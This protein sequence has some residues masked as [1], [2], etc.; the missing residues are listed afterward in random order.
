MTDERADILGW[1]DF[2]ASQTRDALSADDARTARVFRQDR[3]AFDTYALDG[4]EVRARLG[5][6][7]SYRASDRRELPAVGDWVVVKG[8]PE[9][10]ATI[11]DVYDRKSSLMRQAAS[12]ATD[13]QIIAANVDTVFI[14]TSPNQDFNA[15]RLERYL[16]AVQDG[17]AEP[18]VV[19]NK[20]D[21]VDDPSDWVD[22]A[23]EAAGDAHVVT[24][25]AI[26]GHVAALE[27]WLG[28]GETVALVGSSGVGKSTLINQLLG[29]DVQKTGGIREDDG[30]GRHTTVTRELLV[31]P[32]E[33]GLLI[34]TPGLRELQLWAGETQ[35]EEAFDDIEA[36]A[37]ECKFR[38][39]EHQ[40][41]PGCAVRDAV[42][43]GEVSPKRLASWRKL[44]DELDTQRDRQDESSRRS[45][46]FKKR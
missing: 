3:E 18:V 8:D 20:A 26:H 21:L 4:H 14:V 9:K 13:P 34:D 43:A 22:A 33:R 2:F 31:M 40:T 39:C 46:K 44:Q 45:G 7:L 12:K 38:D 41:E 19:L 37:A 32:Q 1:D 16:F 6:G 23:R 28:L 36:L 5:G 27:P 24:A 10:L 17:G 25:S 30:M 15:R 42:E 11:V 29:D 35:A